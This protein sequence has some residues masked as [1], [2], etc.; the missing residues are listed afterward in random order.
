MWDKL[1]DGGEKSRCGWLKDR[2]G[3]SWQ[4]IPSVLGRLL[5]DKD[6]DRARKAMQAM[7]QMT[8][9]DIKDLE[10]AVA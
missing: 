4:I 1:S 8:K 10:D 5:Q 7:M 9:I 6:P 3:I 2:Y